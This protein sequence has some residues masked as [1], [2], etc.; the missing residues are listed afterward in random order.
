VSDVQTE[1]TEPIE[2][3]TFEQFH[4]G[5]MQTLMISDDHRNDV[6]H[7]A[8]GLAEEAGEAMGKLKRAMREDR[9]ALTPARM[10]EL[11]KELGDVQWYLDALAHLIGSSSER[12]ARA[13][14][15]KLADRKARG[16]LT[17]SG[18]NR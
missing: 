9:G 15:K 5:V 8:F 2:P 7:M 10:A 14:L 13:A 16:V 17:G 11:E 1:R 4:E 18:D 12:V 3:L 6:F